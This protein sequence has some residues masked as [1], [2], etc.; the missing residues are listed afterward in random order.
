[1]NIP[2]TKALLQREILGI[3]SRMKVVVPQIPDEKFQKEQSENLD[4]IQI[5]YAK[6]YAD[7]DKLKSLL[8]KTKSNVF[9]V[10]LKYPFLKQVYD[11]ASEKSTEDLD[12][13][14]KELF[15]E[16]STYKIRKQQAELRMKRLRELEIKQD[17]EDD[18]F[19]DINRQK[20]EE[21]IGNLVC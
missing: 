2:A 11:Q 7:H 1:M 10:Q 9:N 16:E 15:S 18:G 6:L 14:A 19:S 20:R 5:E 8:L 12:S 4:H 17:T 21:F 13:K 3:I